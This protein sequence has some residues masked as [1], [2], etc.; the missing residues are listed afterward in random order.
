M[1]SSLANAFD[2]I[3]GLDL[4]IQISSD[5]WT[6]LFSISR[7]RAEDQSSP[8]DN[9]PLVQSIVLL[10][11]I[12]HTL[13][14][15]KLVGDSPFTASLVRDKV[16]ARNGADFDDLLF[17]LRNRLYILTHLKLAWENPELPLTLSA[18][19][20]IAKG[21]LQILVQIFKA[22]G[23]ASSSVSA[24]SLAQDLNTLRSFVQPPQRPTP[25]EEKVTQL[26]DMGFPR[27]ACEMALIRCNNSIARATEYLLMNPHLVANAPP[28]RSSVPSTS[29][30]ETAPS[31]GNEGVAEPNAA[32]SSG[33]NESSVSAMDVA[34]PEDPISSVN[35]DSVMEPSNAT[36]AP[37]NTG[38]SS[39]AAE[40]VEMD[41]DPPQP[42]ES[43][44]KTAGTS[45]ALG[46]SP[47]SKSLPDKE[48]CLDSLNQ[49]RSNLRENLAQT[50][51]S[52]LMKV[53]DIVFAVKELI[54]VK[55]KDVPKN[56]YAKEISKL[57]EFL[58]L[59]ISKLL[60][61]YSSK[62]DLSE[63]LV[64]SVSRVLQL[65]A[66][67]ISDTAFQR[68]VIGKGSDFIHNLLELV[69]SCAAS[70]DDSASLPD[71]F[72]SA[73]LILEAYIVLSHEIQAES[74]ERIPEHGRYKAP[75]K[76]D[77]PP[78]LSNEKTVEL[79]VC[80][81]KILPNEA[82]DS[83][84]AFALLQLLVNLTRRHGIALE[85]V[86]RGGLSALFDPKFVGRFSS[87]QSLSAMI[88]R[89]VIEEKQ[90]LKIMME[91]SITSKLKEA[92]RFKV[93]DLS[94]FVT[95]F[96][97]LVL[98]DQETFLLATKETCQLLK[99][100]H[101]GRQ[102]ISL[103]KPEEDAE[104]SASSSG[105][106]TSAASPVKSGD[107][108]DEVMH[109]L[110][111]KSSETLANFF[112]SELLTL[113]SLSKPLEN[114]AEKLPKTN[115]HLRRCVLLPLMAEL[116]G[117]YPQ[118]K[119]C[120]VAAS[121]RNK[122]GKQSSKSSKNSML[123]HLLNDILPA[124]LEAPPADVNLVSDEK[125]RE[126]LIESEKASLFLQSLCE[127]KME[128]QKEKK[129]FP[130][131]TGARK[132][133]CDAIARSIKDT[134]AATSD[135]LESRYSRFI[136]VS[137]FCMKLIASPPGPKRRV[138]ADEGVIAI[139]KMMLEKNL[140]QLFTQ[141]LMEVDVHHP[142]SNLLL[143]SIL[144]PLEILTKIAI[145][146]GRHPENGSKIKEADIEMEDEGQID[147]AVDVEE[148][149]QNEISEMYR[150]SALGLF[151][152][153]LGHSI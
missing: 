118:F 5:L 46:P 66:I 31:T 49:M 112:V 153:A 11:S 147:A 84:I 41:G 129:T 145:K 117:S 32:E 54:T 131:T 87:Q 20:A 95:Q 56:E 148:R 96:V 86:Q 146:T 132:A 103:G 114:D 110:S 19:P 28:A 111:V 27:G 134:L 58:I 91:E 6:D 35:V 79:L 122:G 71:F 16:K 38:S 50:A 81:C 105:N 150:N 143:N 151:R 10:L 115:V 55:E 152:Y 45:E 60:A 33:Q 12:F 23:E 93:L 22:D 34:T 59:E 85:F 63:Q 17:L 92:S 26:M 109:D 48:Q 47:S 29:G 116:C 135:S 67:L 136:A 62:A 78:P 139:A 120:M 65:Y 121:Q 98:R 128:P 89:H 64:A 77:T 52:L 130:E 144:R 83:N 21:L 138:F 51:V 137:S 7:S 74:L 127:Y 8:D 2:K 1:Q 39:A 9:K 80:I 119:V 88:I 53:D 126:K 104:A 124:G 18:S 106:P 108:Q 4:L 125:K 90:T 15:H 141:M 30:V 100:D 123:S 102:Q 36:E 14:N 37:V 76:L 72:P 40:D 142:S 68:G 70:L 3:E 13:T 101:H 57:G 94:S 43:T 73:L 24:S 44:T 61:L 99:F 149:N 25:D 69:Q 140:V 97:P 82:V 107:T 42:V 113:R 133:V 75:E